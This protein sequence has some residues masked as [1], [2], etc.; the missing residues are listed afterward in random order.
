MNVVGAR[1][2]A[3]FIVLGDKKICC[4]EMHQNQGTQGINLV[5]CGYVKEECWWQ[6]PSFRVKFTL[7][8]EAEAGLQVDEAAAQGCLRLA[9]VGGHDDVGDFGWIEVSGC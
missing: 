7:W 1:N 5:K 2:G 8:L 3:G 6:H 4:M 9:G